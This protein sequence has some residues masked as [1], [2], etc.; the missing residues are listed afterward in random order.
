MDKQQITEKLKVCLGDEFEVA[1]DK[2]STEALLKDDLGFD[3]LDMVDVIVLLNEEFEVKLT[4][5]DF[6]HCRTFGQLVD[7]LAARAR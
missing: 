7:L 4:S 3:S 6:V 2:F 1:H 5:E